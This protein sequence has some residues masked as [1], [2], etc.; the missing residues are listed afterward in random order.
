MAAYSGIHV[1]HQRKPKHCFD[2]MEP[3][4]VR[5]NVQQILN[6]LLVQQMPPSLPMGMEPAVKDLVADALQHEAFSPMIV[7]YTTVDIFMI[8]IYN[9][10]YIYI[11]IISPWA[12][13]SLSALVDLSNQQSRPLVYKE[14]QHQGLGLVWYGR[15]HPQHMACI[16]GALHVANAPIAWGLS[17]GG[18]ATYRRSPTEAF[19]G[20]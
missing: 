16:T 20:R 5:G 3:S 6:M 1:G 13:G 4:D 12:F 18:P 2:C 11:Y 17:G 19:E 14:G 9:H 15:I 10:N 7:R 8:I